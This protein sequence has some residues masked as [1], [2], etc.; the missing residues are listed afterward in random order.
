MM[1]PRGKDEGV[2]DSWG[3]LLGDAAASRS[4]VPVSE[5][6]PTVSPEAAPGSAGRGS[7]KP[8]D[9]P[10][11]ADAATGEAGAPKETS[12]EENVAGPDAKTEP[13]RQRPAPPRMGAAPADNGGGRWVALVLA[14]AGLGGLYVVAG[15][16]EKPA[17]ERMAAAPALEKARLLS[18]ASSRGSDPY[19]PGAG[20]GPVRD[21]P[22]PSPSGEPVAP[23]TPVDSPPTEAVA[24]PPSP[25]PEPPAPSSVGG[26]LRAAPAESS[27]EAAA[28]FKRL[29]LSPEDGPPLAGI[30]A[31]GIHVDSLSMG[32][33]VNRR[34]YCQG[35]DSG[36]SVSDRDRVNVCFR[37]VHHRVDDEELSVLWQK[38]GGTKRRT[39]VK[40][41]AKK[42]AH[43]TRAFLATRSEYVGAWTVKIVSADGATLAQQSFDVVE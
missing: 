15:G 27:P 1:E 11:K 39:K 36:Y 30:G 14:V 40:V 41:P 33:E 3:D 5:G 38:D 7:A 34:G 25:T 35:G 18:P 24:K 28:E 9:A 43:R 4:R 17:E 10:S 23:P 12:K 32:T 2:D 19:P 42:H 29:P 31:T 8:A 26:D 13:P 22:P 20:S 16:D 37:A 21:E 6:G